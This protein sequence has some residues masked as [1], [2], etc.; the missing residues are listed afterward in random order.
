MFE[1]LGEILY[2]RVYQVDINNRTIVFFLNEINILIIG[3]VKQILNDIIHL[4]HSFF[5]IV[6]GID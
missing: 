1:F 2:D 6:N 5:G 3:F 4:I